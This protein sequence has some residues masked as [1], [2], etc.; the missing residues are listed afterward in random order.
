MRR[1]EYTTARPWRPCTSTYQVNFSCHRGI[2]FG[3]YI[4]IPTFAFHGSKYSKF[5]LEQPAICPTISIKVGGTSRSPQNMILSTANVV[6]RHRSH[7][8]NQCLPVGVEFICLMHAVLVFFLAMPGYQGVELSK[9][10]ELWST[11]MVIALHVS[12]NFL[13]LRVNSRCCYCRR[14]MMG[15]NLFLAL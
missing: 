4:S 3:C 1:S 12:K 8:R 6:M 10:R 13:H 7:S 14:P 5:P 15:E 2:R 9:W 11:N